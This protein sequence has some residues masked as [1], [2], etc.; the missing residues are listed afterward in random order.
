MKKRTHRKVCNALCP[1][2]TRVLAES[3][4]C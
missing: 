3:R 2:S 1:Y 4:R